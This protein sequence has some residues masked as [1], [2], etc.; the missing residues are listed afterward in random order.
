MPAGIAHLALSQNLLDQTTRASK[1]V[2][3]WRAAKQIARST[4]PLCLVGGI[5]AFDLIRHSAVVGHGWLLSRRR[6]LPI[7]KDGAPLPWYTYPAIAFLI[8]RLPSEIDVFEYGCG[9]STL[10]WTRRARSVISVEHAGPWA[11]TIRQ[12][13]DPNVRVIEMPTG[14]EEDYA[15]TIAST[16][17]EFDVVVV[18]GENREGCLKIAPENLKSD[19]I[20]ILDNS[21][22]PAYRDGISNLCSKGFRR[23]DFIGMGPINTYDWTTSI[24]YRTANCVDL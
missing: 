3:W 21:E 17:M 18:D 9:Y 14:R 23:V 5:N 20:I 2:T 11:Q 24:F 8:A 4:L 13:A 12:M 15:A 10:W 1:H 16:G 22:R 19:G 6:G 7:D